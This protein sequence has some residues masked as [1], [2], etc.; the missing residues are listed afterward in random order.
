MVVVQLEFK[1]IGQRFRRLIVAVRDGSSEV[2]PNVRRHMAA[3]CV[4]LYIAL[5]SL[6][7]MLV[8]RNILAWQQRWL[9]LLLERQGRF[10]IITILRVLILFQFNLELDLVLKKVVSWFVPYLGKSVIEHPFVLGPLRHLVAVRPRSIAE[11]LL[12]LFLLLDGICHLY[13]R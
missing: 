8:V 9:R 5:F 12:N 6:V 2:R 1:F 13:P 3:Q 10:Q 7:N 11:P 4:R